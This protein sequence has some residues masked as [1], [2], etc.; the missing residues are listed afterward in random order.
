[1]IL[2]YA[3]GEDKSTG[4]YLIML[5]LDENNKINIINAIRQNRISSEHSWIIFRDFSKENRLPSEQEI[6]EALKD[7][8]IL[9]K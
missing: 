3:K 8:L 9:K 2:N 1:M 7:F 6:N 5:D 4:T